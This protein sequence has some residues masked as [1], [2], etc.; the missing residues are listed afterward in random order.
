VLYFNK[1]DFTNAIA[2]H[3]ALPNYWHCA[4]HRLRP[5]LLRIDRERMADEQGGVESR[6]EGRGLNPFENSNK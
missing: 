1:E 5:G 6:R 3:G 2:M 4:T